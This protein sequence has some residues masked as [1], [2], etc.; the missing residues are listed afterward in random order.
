M[1]TTPRYCINCK[2]VGTS[3][4]GNL[5]NFK[6]FAPQN[7]IGTN[8]VD[9][10]KIFKGNCVQLRNSSSPQGEICGNYGEWFELAP[11]K[12]VYEPTP[13]PINKPVVGVKVKLK[14]SNDDLLRALG[15][16]L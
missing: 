4:S 6:C 8:M 5:E 13:A 7:I 1:D 11:P 3:S 12:P 10:S 2:H 16:G 15:G 9:G 14:G